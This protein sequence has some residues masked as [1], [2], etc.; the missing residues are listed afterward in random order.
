MEMTVL[1]ATS[2]GLKYGVTVGRCGD[3]IEILDIKPKTFITD[4]IMRLVDEAVD[5]KLREAQA[6]LAD[7]M[8]DARDD[9]RECA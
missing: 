5:E 4:E 6:D 2:D 8:L 9:Y 7:R 3:D 1:I